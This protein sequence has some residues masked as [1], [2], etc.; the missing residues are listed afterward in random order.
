M[1]VGVEKY[2]LSHILRMTFKKKSKNSIF[3]HVLP[4]SATFY[5]IKKSL[6]EKSW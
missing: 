2:G 5:E 1:T 6:F 3:G 4:I